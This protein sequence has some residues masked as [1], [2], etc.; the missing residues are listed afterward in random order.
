MLGCYQ[1][2]GR[3]GY[4]RPWTAPG[5]SSHNIVCGVMALQ[6]RATSSGW[7]ARSALLVLLVASPASSQDPATGTPN[8]LSPHAGPIAVSGGLVY[9]A[10]T[11]GATLD[12]L[13]AAS[14]ELVARVRV[15]V[16]PV[17]VAV[18]PDGREVWVANHVSDA[19]SVVDTDSSSPTYLQ[20]VATVQDLDPVSRGTRF[21][22]PV[23]V[24]FA[25]DEK[26]YVSLSSENE[27]AVVDVATRSVVRRLSITAQDPRALAVRGNRLFVAPFESNNQT[28]LSGCVGPIDGELCTF[29]AQE[30]VVDNNN[31]LSLGYD[32][33]IVRH[34]AVPD[35]DLFVFDTAT[36]ALVEVVDTV[37]TLLYGMAVDSV[38]R[39]FVAQTEA[40]NDANGRAG[41]LKHGLAEMG[42]RPFLNR[43]TRVD[44]AGAS[45][46]PPE[47]LELEPLP[48]AEPAPDAALATP[49]AISVSADDRTLVATAASSDVL[50]TL[51]AASGAVLGRVAV[52]AVPRGVA[53]ESA[54]DGAATRAWVLNAVDNS[55]SLVDL[56]DRTQ[57]QLAATIPLDDPTHLVVKLG[58]VAFSTARASTGGTFSCESCH[59]DGHTDQLLWVLDTP[60]CNVAGCTQVPPRS[61]MPIRGLRDTAPYHWD[62]IPGDPYGGPNT[63][64]IGTSV[65]ASCDPL[66][67][68]SCTRQLLDGTLATTMCLVDDCPINDE[69][70]PGA[71]DATERDALARFLLSV[72]YPPAQRRSYDNVLSTTATTGFRVFHIDGVP[73][74]QPGDRANVCGNCHRLPFWVSTNTPGTGMD[75][76]TWRG[77]YDRWLILP[78]GRWNVVDLRRQSERDAGFPERNM[79]GAA[80]GVQVPFWNMVTEGSTGFSG[81]YARTLTLSRST[82]TAE[83]TSDLLAALELADQEGAVFLQGEG[84]FIEHDTVT[85]ARF[86][87]GAGFYLEQDGA[88]RA[89][90]RSALVS[91]AREGEF[92]GTFI[93]RVG[94]NVDLDHP[95]PALWT[96]GPIQDQQGR[97]VFPRDFGD[98]RALQI[99][100]RHVQPGAKL[101]VDGRRVDGT[102]RC[103]TGVLPSCTSEIIEVDLAQSPPVSGLHF[104]Q[105]QNPDGLFSNEFIFHRAMAATASAV[106]APGDTMAGVATDTVLLSLPR[107]PVVDGVVST[108]DGL[109]FELET[110]AEGFE[111]PARAAVVPDGRVLVSDAAGRLWFVGADGQRAPAPALV[112]PE[113]LVPG[114]GDVP[115]VVVDPAFEK[116]GFIYVLYTRQLSGTSPTRQLV[117]YRAVEE[118][119]AEPAV[120]ID[121]LPAGPGDTGRLAIGGDQQLYVALG[122][123]GTEPA[124]AASYRGKVLRIALDGTTPVDNPFLSP[125]FAGGLRQPLTLAWPS[126]SESLWVADL[127][128][129]GTLGITPVTAGSVAPRGSAVASLASVESGSGLEVMA[130]A[131]AGAVSAAPVF[132]DLFLTRRQGAFLERWRLDLETPGRVVA[133]ERLLRDHVPPLIDV[134]AGPD[135]TL[136]LIT[137][138]AGSAG[139]ALLRLTPLLDFPVLTSPGRRISLESR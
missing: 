73:G 138:N 129:S 15:G 107:M 108:A 69:G 55:V 104:L 115:E 18:R 133:S 29:D 31:V 136:Y 96:L 66:V 130:V 77:A 127:D 90:S 9:V 24:V 52:G 20:V 85:A 137:D 8:F 49:Y 114:A 112:L 70:L 45:C 6:R 61:T 123:A 122:D 79:W 1:G 82:A 39:V 16:D 47:F 87:Y 27:V 103:Q 54:A 110:M 50:F 65:T 59:P 14:L 36:D 21:D 2:T 35:R 57:P 11:P 44:C 64:N 80:F 117:R 76:P 131:F 68:E 91:M 67:P 92:V 93:G 84:V 38:G 128:S 42:N 106:S 48:P 111:A 37:G 25:S 113:V 101:F 139:A 89:F 63:A 33:D 126:E 99:S 30:H 72:P 88:R 19:V 71:L 58:R 81:A 119:F 97:Q 121:A 13:D 118:R 116:S 109:R 100:A 83:L 75:A 62:G 74:D 32:A 26:A 43:V 22:E 4:A 53:L 120:L 40:R 17:G 60:V 98:G 5:L 10:N 125:I 3:C 95:Q 56:T 94:P 78:Q 132:R 46:G 51:D 23:G 124:E 34:P 7:G 102:L 135:G 12:V 105:V 86:A 41:T 134:E 28:Q